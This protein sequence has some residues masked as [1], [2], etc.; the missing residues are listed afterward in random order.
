VVHGA[1][2]MRLYPP[3]YFK[4]CRKLC[5]EFNVLLICDEIAT[6][7]GRT[8]KLFAC[9][10]A[11]ISPDILCLGKALTGG[12]LTMA[13]TLCTDE[14]A[15]GTCVGEPGVFMHGPTYM[16]NPLACAVANASIDLILEGT[17]QQQVPRIEK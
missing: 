12:Y 16:G 6:G 15:E 13:A 3:D 10:H 4:A 2:G 8:G 14:V 5:D 11:Q 17:W 1:G 7:F 9:E